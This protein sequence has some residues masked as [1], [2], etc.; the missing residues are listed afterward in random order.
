M[1]RNLSISRR[2]VLKGLGTA[3]ALPL[4]EAMAPAACLADSVRK[5]PTRMAFLYVPNGIHMPE[6]TPATEG[7]NFTL[8]FVLEPLQS[9]QK[10]MLVLSGLTLDK[11]RAHGD[12]GGD[13]AR[14]I[15][16]FLTGRHPKK[17]GGA[18]IRA[19][20]SVDQYA[21][22][23]Q[24]KNTPFPSLE[25]GCD[26]RMHAG[27]CDTGYS[28]AYSSNM[29]WKTDTT[30]MAKEI[31]PRLVFERL[32]A[33]Q[34][35]EDSAASIGMRDRHRLSV[36][37]F[38]LDDARRLK[39]KLSSNDQKKLDGYLAA[40]RDVEMRLAR[41]TA[42]A[43]QKQSN[44]KVTKY[45]RPAGIPADFQEHI[46]LMAD[47]IVLAFRADLTRIVTFVIAHDGSNR[48][49][50]FIGVPEGHHEMSHHG[51]L[52]EKQKKIRL[53]NHFHVS[54]LAYL[55]ER[56]RATKEGDHTL[57]DSSMIVYGS[58]ISDGNAHNHDNLPILLAGRA[59][60]TLQPGRHIRY[61]K[62]TPLMNLY[63]SMLDRMGAP[64]DSFGD[65]TGR[66]PGLT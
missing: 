22:D 56:L 30:P 52:K 49:Y 57:L 16:T 1:T 12:G 61:P 34:I 37:D 31:N 58:G 63:L 32:F 21:A 13:H 18:D 28:C 45:D 26:G 11:A 55:L 6:W 44:R 36:L 51:G 3:I 7:E 60:G 64:A 17:T 24:G 38:V 2:T 9:F 50:N 10:D 25:L 5:S 42:H 39:T 62:E 43:S 29:S 41:A 27:T 66:L 54:Q 47:M 65:S 59:N 20:I 40:I 8:P 14:A 4:L 15:S 46:R 19:G 48:S 33:D 23:R 35:K 53:I